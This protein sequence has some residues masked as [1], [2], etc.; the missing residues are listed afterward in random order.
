MNF[1]DLKI[2]RP[3]EFGRHSLFRVSQAKNTAYRIKNSR[4][5]VIYVGKHFFVG[6]FTFSHTH[7]RGGLLR[8]PRRPVFF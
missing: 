2:K 7:T 1:S 3:K 6:Y 4:P 8:G 5:R